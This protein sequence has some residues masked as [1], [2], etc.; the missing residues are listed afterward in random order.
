MQRYILAKIFILKTKLKIPKVKKYL[1]NKRTNAELASDFSLTGG[2]TR[3]WRIVF[4]FL[5]EN[6]LE[7]RVLLPGETSLTCESKIKALDR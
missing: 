6:D 7:L 1:I 2:A 3:Q 5:K 4:I